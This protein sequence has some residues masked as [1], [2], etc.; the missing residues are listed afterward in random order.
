MHYAINTI[1]KNEG[2]ADGVRLAAEFDY[3][4]NDPNAILSIKA[5]LGSSSW[6]ETRGSY[7]TIGKDVV[8]RYD[9]KE[10]A[11]LGHELEHVYQGSL[12]AWSIQGEVLAY[13][14]EYRIRDAMGVAQSSNTQAAMDGDGRGYPYDPYNLN[15]LIDAR[16]GFLNQ[17][18]YNQPIEPTLPWNQQIGYWTIEELCNVASTATTISEFFIQGVE[19]G[20][21]LFNQAQQIFE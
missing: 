19:N 4:A 8:T 15:D 5:S 14:T 17:H 21:N 13:Q 18:P 1:L 2:G 6:M 11:L 3:Y 12:L 10:I 20:L 9:R 16:S 7:I